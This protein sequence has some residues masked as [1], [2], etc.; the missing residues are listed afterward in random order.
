ME[1]NLDNRGTGKHRPADEAGRTRM[2]G[3]SSS[4]SPG[5]ASYLLPPAA[6]QKRAASPSQHSVE[7][8]VR[9]RLAVNHRVGQLCGLVREYPKALDPR[10]M[11]AAVEMRGFSAVQAAV[12]VLVLLGRDKCNRLLAAQTAKRTQESPRVSRLLAREPKSAPS[13]AGW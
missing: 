13:A 6:P 11:S 4:G 7:L 3:R 12:V 8:E 10:A 1:K 2:A 5:V 9:V